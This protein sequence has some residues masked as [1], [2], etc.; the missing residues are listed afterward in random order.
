MSVSLNKLPNHAQYTVCLVIRETWRGY[1]RK[2]LHWELQLCQAILNATI[3]TDVAAVA[4][5]VRSILKINDLPGHHTCLNMCHTALQK[6]KNTARLSML[7]T[8]FEAPAVN[9]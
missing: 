7:Q 8:H 1:V 4:C 3:E 9:T 5:S 2:T 6:K